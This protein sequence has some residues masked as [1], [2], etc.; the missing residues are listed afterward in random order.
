MSHPPPKKSLGQNFLVDETHRN[1]IVAA[2][3]LTPADTVLE[4]GPVSVL[5]IGASR[6]VLIGWRR[7]KDP[8]IDWRWLEERPGLW[9]Y[10]S[11]ACLARTIACVRLATCNLLKM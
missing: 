9:T 7:R 6:S 10:P 4:I 11:P 8:A 5:E 2:A 3:D 1:R